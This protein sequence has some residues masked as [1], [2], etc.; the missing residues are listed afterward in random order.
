VEPIVV[1]GDMRK[2]FT[3]VEMLVV[4]ILI[5]VLFAVAVPLIGKNA[6][7]AKENALRYQLRQVRDAQ[8]RYFALYQGWPD[9]IED[10][11]DIKSSSRIWFSATHNEQWGSRP[12]FGPI[13]IQG[14]SRSESWIKDPVSGNNFS[15]TRLANGEL[16]IRSS[17]SGRDSNGVSFSSY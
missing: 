4:I 16:R 9:D 2:A 6:R 5:A 3:L 17:A 7:R 13:L 8:Q 12:Y 11:T 10:L 15:T 14:A 1:Q